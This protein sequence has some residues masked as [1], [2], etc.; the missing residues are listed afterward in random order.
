MLI[1][2]DLDETLI[3]STA[4]EPDSGYSFKS[5]EYFVRIRPFAKE[6][7]KE[8]CDR[9]TVAVWTSSTRDYAEPI[10]QNLSISSKIEFLW[11]R[12]RCTLMRDAETGEEYARD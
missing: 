2:L 7:L 9:Y 10:V 1:I 6:F 11:T 4:H 5:C 8:I 12:N 3:N